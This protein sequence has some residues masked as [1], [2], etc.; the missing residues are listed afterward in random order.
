MSGC[1]AYEP[2]KR[3]NFQQLKQALA[4]IKEE[5][6]AQ[7]TQVQDIRLRDIKRIHSAPGEASSTLGQSMEQVELNT[8]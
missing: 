6:R 8:P 5:E 2:S 1:W 3:P 7:V 4:E